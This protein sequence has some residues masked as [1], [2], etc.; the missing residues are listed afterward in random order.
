MNTTVH[1]FAPE[2]IMAFVDGELSADCMQSL[3]AHVDQCAECSTLATDLRGLSP[4]MTSWQ[5]EVVPE[6]LS[7]RVT[8]VAVGKFTKGN[9]PLGDGLKLGHSPALSL[10]LRVAAVFA[11]VLLVLAISIPNLLRSKMA[12]N[13]ASAVGSLRTLNTA[14]VT[15]LSTY[16][17]FPS[18]LKSFGPPSNGAP[19]EDAAGLVDPM[20]AGGRKSGYL[21]TYRSV[22]GFGSAR[23]GTY[24]IR[25]EPVKLG[26]SGYRHFS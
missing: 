8:A 20:L 15:Y 16:G 17:H 6:R 10:T 3:S 23:A 26:D 11:G 19:A 18:S 12:A 4:Q 9:H 7:A 21:F 1:P 22:P 14:A 24:A 2:E 25:A 5:V 13:E